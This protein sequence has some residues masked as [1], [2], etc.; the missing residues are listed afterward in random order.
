MQHLPIDEVARRL[1]REVA[2]TKCERRPPRSGGLGPEVSRACEVSCPLFFHLPLLVQLAGQVDD[3]PG[4]CEMAVK[5]RVCASCSLAP[6]AG[7]YCADYAARSCPLSRYSRDVL[8]AL[9]RAV[10]GARNEGRAS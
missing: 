3:R 6:T 5:S 9:Q 7:E 4:S 1:V 8:G 10:Q 2:C